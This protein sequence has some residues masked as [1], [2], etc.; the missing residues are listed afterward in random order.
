MLFIASGAVE[1]LFLIIVSSRILNRQLAAW[2]VAL[3]LLV[4]SAAAWASHAWALNRTYTLL[5][6]GMIFA[7][8]Y[9][10]LRCGIKKTT[11]AVFAGALVT[12]FTE[13]LLIQALQKV[14]ALPVANPEIQ[15]MALGLM[16]VVLGA[17][18][19]WVPLQMLSEPRIVGSLIYKIVFLNLCFT[20]LILWVLW[21][22]ESALFW[23]LSPVLLVLNVLNVFIIIA[24]VSGEVKR[25]ESEREAQLQNQYIPILQS[26]LEDARSRQHADRNHLQAIETAAFLCVQKRDAFHSRAHL[27]ESFTESLEQLRAYIRTYQNE[28]ELFLLPRLDNIVLTGLIYEKNMRC[29]EQGILFGVNVSCSSFGE[30][31]STYTVVEMIGAL[32]DNAIE[33][34]A[35]QIHPKILL[36]LSEEGEIYYIEISNTFR[37]ASREEV[38][39]WMRPGISTKGPGRGIGLPHVK[40]RAEA[41][42]GGIQFENRQGKGNEVV[43]TVWFKG[44]RLR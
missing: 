19:R 16:L 36:S 12:G 26:L 8:L 4:L 9:G 5:S 21:K 41:L 11:Y 22:M 13:L 15:V 27:S 17:V 31:A 1:G 25:V 43:F 7:L 33:A 28:S 42:G 10:H 6:F 44:R 32:L 29:R 34:C 14:L 39:Q 38:A 20:M 40:N 30:G 23:D 24:L 2:K 18:V 35:Q 37:R 3:S